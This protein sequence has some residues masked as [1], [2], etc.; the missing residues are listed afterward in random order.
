MPVL[1]RVQQQ[2]EALPY[3]HRDPARELEQLRQPMVCELPRVNSL[4]WAGR[5][6]YDR[7]FRVL[8]AGCGTGDNTMF[9]GE[10][11]R[12]TGAEIVALDFSTASLAIARERAAVRGLDGVRF[13]HAPIEDAPALG[14]GEFDF[15]VCSGVLHHLAS[16]EDG[17]RALR[18]MLKPD[19]G[20]AL[21][22]YATYG[23]QPVYLM[24][25]LMRHLAPAHLGP[26]R[27]LAILRTALE[28]LP[29]S[30]RTRRGLLEDAFFRDEITRSDAGAYDLLLHTQDRAYTVP[31]L[32]D[33]ATAAGTR[34][35]EWVVPK[36]YDPATYLPGVPVA[37]GAPDAVAELM[38]GGMTKHECFLERDDAPA[39]ERVVADDPA[40]VPAWCAWGFGDQVAAALGRLGNEFRCTFGPEREVVVPVDA[41]ARHFFASIDGT[42][43]VGEILEGATARQPSVSRRQATRR[44]VEFCEAFRAVAALALSAGGRSGDA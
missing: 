11:L 36:A 23:R 38:H 15:I 21:M 31:E 4:L 10:Q 22:V 35:L 37:D 6:R 32:H 28:R 27:R 26:D 9:L 25:S 42:R 44:W 34:V 5:R 43:T 16:P 19:G 7:T 30:A 40:A 24:Q 41:L 3:P 18:S 17:L 14:L 13:V 20:I 29:A 12:G 33:W 39:R 1:E 8:D 2:Y